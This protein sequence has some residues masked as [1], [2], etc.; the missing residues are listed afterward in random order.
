MFASLG[1]A[2]VVRIAMSHAVFSSCPMFS[3]AAAAAADA[4][5][6]VACVQVGL[7]VLQYLAWVVQASIA[8]STAAA[9]A[10]VPGP[11]S[12]NAANGAAAAAAGLAEGVLAKK[13]LELVRAVGA[14]D[15]AGERVGS[16]SVSTCSLPGD[17]PAERGWFLVGGLGA[18]WLRSCYWIWSKRLEPRRP[19]E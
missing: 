12:S 11:D 8:A 15:T 10:A 1:I 17:V 18:C 19:L 9:A 2:D 4:A 3:S 6:Y 7:T 5:C 16:L 13:L 14:Q